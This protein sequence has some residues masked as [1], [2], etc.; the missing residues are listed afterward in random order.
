MLAFPSTLY[1]GFPSSFVSMPLSLSGPSFSPSSPPPTT[2]PGP[3]LPLPLTY[4]RAQAKLIVILSVSLF[5]S[6]TIFLGAT[7]NPNQCV[8]RS[9]DQSIDD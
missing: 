6:L 4:L 5:T 3:P 1:F 9:I 7:W 8:R 2:T